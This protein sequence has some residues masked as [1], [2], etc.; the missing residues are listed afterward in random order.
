MST[1][2]RALRDR[3]VLVTG[4]GS[5]LGRALALKFAQKGWRVACSDLR[6][7]TADATAAEIRSGGGQALAFAQDVTSE[8]SWAEAVA[9][10]QREWNGLDVLVNNAGVATAGTV[11]DSPIA[12]WEWVLNINL[13]GCVRGARAVIPLLSAQRGGH[14][15]NIASFAG[16][17]NPP[18]M[19]SYNVAKAGVISLSETL[20]FEMAP[21]GVG[22]SVA[23]PSFFKTALMETSQASAPAVGEN[24]APQVQK[25]VTRLMQ[26]ATVTADHV[27]SDILDA[28]DKNRFLVITHP[29]ARQRYH[30]KRVAPEL[31]FRFARKATEAFLGKR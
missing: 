13:L 9:T 30:L 14:I 3:R 24:A 10:L 28:V 18:A 23:C 12:Q 25:I 17:A 15:V 5:G 26:K 4:A 31:Y 11:A 20:R 2:E 21:L 1:I 27:A 19:A 29:D 6:A 22:V 8:A 16:I 7:E